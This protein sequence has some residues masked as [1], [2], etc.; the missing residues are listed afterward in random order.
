MTWQLHPV[1]RL[2]F[3]L[4]LWLHAALIASGAS[5]SPWIN[6]AAILG[7]SVALLCSENKR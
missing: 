2:S 5:R 3:A 6:A 7:F 4:W 1:L